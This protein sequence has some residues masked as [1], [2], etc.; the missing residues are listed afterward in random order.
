[1]EVRELDVVYAL[2]EGIDRETEAKKQHGT[3][4]EQEQNKN[5]RNRKRDRQHGRST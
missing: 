5:N 4:R 3:E 1:M 2:S